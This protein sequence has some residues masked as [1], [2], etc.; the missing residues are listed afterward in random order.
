MGEALEIMGLLNQVYLRNDLMNWA[1]WLNNFCVLIVME[2]FLIWPP[3]YSVSLTFILYLLFIWLTIKPNNLRKFYSQ[4][5]EKYDQTS[6][7]A[8]G[9]LWQQFC[10]F[11]HLSI[12]LSVCDIFLRIYS[13]DDLNYLHKDIL[14]YILERDKA[15][16]WKYVF[17]F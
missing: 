14:L 16:F 17:V 1:Y 9:V 6:I 15:R 3:M 8:E 13:V 5:S 12:C 4:I 10:S 7:F 11:V 2:C